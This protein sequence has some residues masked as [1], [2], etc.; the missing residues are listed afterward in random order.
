ML[1]VPY[2]LCV[3]LNRAMYAEDVDCS[4]DDDY[5]EEEHEA[6]EPEVQP[7]MKRKR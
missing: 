2:P 3:P 1:L 6:D 5:V 4:D 7:T